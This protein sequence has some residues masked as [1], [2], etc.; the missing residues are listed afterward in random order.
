V[1]EK[2]TN[3]V[4]TRNVIRV[5]QREGVIGLGKE[6]EAAVIGVILGRVKIG[7]RSYRCNNSS[8]APEK[9]I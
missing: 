3:P 1:I 6:A 4:Q 2:S 9:Q 8:G 7:S 5:A